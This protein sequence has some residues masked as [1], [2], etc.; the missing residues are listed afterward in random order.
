M[1]GFFMRTKLWSGIGVLAAAAASVGAANA[2]DLP[3]KAPVYK[4]PPP[5][6]VS[7]WSGFYIGAAGGYGWG[8]TSFDWA[9]APY[10]NASPKGG[11]FGGYAGYNWQFGSWVTGLEVDGSWANLTTTSTDF[12]QKTDTLGS[13]RGRFG[14]TVLPSLLAYGTVGA[15]W[16][17]TTLDLT[18]AGA[19]FFTGPGS[20]S[21]TQFGWV[22]GAGLEYKFYGNWIARAEYLHYDFGSQNFGFV[23]PLPPQVSAS[24][25]VDLVRGGLSYKF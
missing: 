19:S 18:P 15:G 24:E 21:I 9:D 3:V 20:S 8:S 2:A 5:V 23:V 10:D 11:L 13:V 6:I 1:E 7:D 4:A 25:T 16:G 14:Y 22:A 17:H 12:T